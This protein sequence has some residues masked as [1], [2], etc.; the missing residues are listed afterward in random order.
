MI[1][2]VRAQYVVNVYDKIWRERDEDFG[3]DEY[4]SEQD[5]ERER[6][7]ECVCASV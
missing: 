7:R 1:R 2:D 5:R 4:E 3:S 6:V